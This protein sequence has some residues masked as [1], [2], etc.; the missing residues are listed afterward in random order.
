M[1]DLLLFTQ[2]DSQ[3]E[4]LVGGKGLSLALTSQAGLPVPPGF[5][6]TTD[7][8]RAHADQP[9]TVECPLGQAIL[10]AYRGL[11]S[12]LVAVRS[13]ATGEDGAEMSF[14]GQQ[15][16]FLGIQGAEAVLDAIQRCWASLK[17]ERAR[18]Y[19]Q[20]QGIDEAGL[21]MAVVVQQLIPAESA[22]V[23]FTTDP[24]DVSGKR[25]LIESS[26]GLGESVVS[27]RV[28]PDRFHLDRDTGTVLE[29]HLAHKT[30]QA[31]VQ[32][33]EELPAH[34][35]DQASL[36]DAQLTQLAALARRVEGF[37][38]EPRDV[39]W[40]WAEG[41]VWLLQ[42]RP[43]TTASAAERETVRQE[44][45]ACLR[46]LTHPGGT[47]WSRF[48]LAE[49]LSEPTP[50][51]WAIVRRF[52]SGRGGYGQ[53]YRELGFDPDPALDDAGI[54][55]LVAGRPYCNL[56]REARMHFRLLPL[57][58]D[59]AAIKADPRKAMYPTPTLNF[60][61]VGCLGLLFFPVSLIRTMSRQVQVEG[62]KKQL[63]S[64]F[65]HRYREEIAP[66]FLRECDQGDGESLAGVSDREL[67]VC[68]EQWTQRTLIDFARE[69]L[70]PTALAAFGL[71]GL[72]ARLASWL[73]SD[74]AETIARSL[75]VGVHPDPEADLPQALEQLTQGTLDRAG[76]L[77]RF[78]H[79]G[80]QEMELSRP[81]WN[82][83][84]ALVDQLMNSGRKGGTHTAGAGQVESVLTTLLHEKPLSEAQEKSLREE[85][86]SLHTFLGLRETAKHHLLRGY[87]LI[88]K[89]LVEL[90]RRHGLG[91]GVFYLLPEELPRLIK[92]ERFRDQ[93]AQRKRR[94]TIAL[95]LEVPPV[96]FSD[97]LEALG[98][99]NVPSGATS[100]QGV[101]LSAGVAEAQ[102]LVL[103]EPPTQTPEG[104]YVLVCPSTDPAWVPLFVSAR[105]LVMETGGILSHGAIV[106]REF[107]LPAVAGLP[108]AT[109]Q[110]KTGQRLK[111]DGA[112]GLVTILE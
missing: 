3:G 108:G 2:I 17:S 44:E 56:S 37:Y 84:P 8:Y 55:D 73:G 66:T 49:V 81:R 107:G 53:M 95:S 96:L 4:S 51:T 82:E 86:Q 112:S 48:N 111:V 94:R 24:L 105:A 12:G 69:S 47:I 33:R 1:P 20:K 25:L 80:P 19:R 23:L 5:C 21:A 71:A 15:E 28:Q 58:H 83:D 27:G 13:S 74:R 67:L 63:N 7:A 40:A 59:F 110:L 46:T 64:T 6:V 65:A 22:G 29:R 72:Q 54:F 11:G 42:A 75:V 61:R 41:T 87:A 32:G 31:T 101:P 50:L 90:D 10:T 60:A 16:T 89:V 26:W 97:D 34:L 99:V 43:I 9:L 76:F 79:R 78:G 30:E 18:A 77:R 45:I 39:E 35:R 68:L 57:D 52:M 91:G 102:A 38:G 92:G 85:I 109:R 98:R 104:P 100:L 70:K 106:A 93:I 88:R 103:T 62:I 36:T 14:A